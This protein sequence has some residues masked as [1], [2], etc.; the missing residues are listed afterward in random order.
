MFVWVV[1]VCLNI[2]FSLSPLFLF[3]LY[4][5]LWSDRTGFEELNLET[6]AY[7][8]PIVFIVKAAAT[9]T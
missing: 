8:Y 9:K 1:A 7:W 2:S 4:S 5:V 6:K 3:N